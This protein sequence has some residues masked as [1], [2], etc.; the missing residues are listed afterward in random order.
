MRQAYGCSD[1]HFFSRMSAA[2]SGCLF[3]VQ[4]KF[5]PDTQMKNRFDSS[6]KPSRQE[7]QFLRLSSFEQ[8]IDKL[9]TFL[10]MEELPLIPGESSS[11]NYLLAIKLTKSKISQLSKQ[12]WISYISLIDTDPFELSGHMSVVY[13]S[14]SGGGWV[15]QL[16][17]LMVQM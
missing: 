1:L 8:R 5:A 17:R 2:D 7:K 10:G 13:G 9:R 6:P 4:I 3:D 11:E 16:S 12:N 14:G 15:C